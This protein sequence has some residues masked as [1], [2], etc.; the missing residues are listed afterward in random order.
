LSDRKY[1]RYV[2]HAYFKLMGET[3]LDGECWIKKR[4]IKG[5]PIVSVEGQRYLASR[6]VLSIHH[7]L[8]LKDVV[9]LACHLCDNPQC[10][11]P[12]HLYV[13]DKASN[14]RDI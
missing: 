6:V 7:D 1:P 8:D 4:P 3:T 2:E 11:N 13:G 9:A 14:A 12:Y 10:Y 5:R